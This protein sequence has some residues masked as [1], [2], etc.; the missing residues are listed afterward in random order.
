MKFSAG[1]VCNSARIWYDTDETET[2]RVL[3]PGKRLL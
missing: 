3:T 2:I 1:G